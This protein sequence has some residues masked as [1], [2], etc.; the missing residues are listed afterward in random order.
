M[1]GIG[2]LRAGSRVLGCAE[3]WDWVAGGAGGWGAG[4]VGVLGT[5]GYWG[6][7]VSGMLGTRGLRCW[8]AAGWDIGVLRNGEYIGEW[9]LVLG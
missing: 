8:E 1:W 4:D 9:E 2:V 3:D 5:G 7:Q 6:A